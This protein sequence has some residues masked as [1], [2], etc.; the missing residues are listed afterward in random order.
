MFKY[1][2][3][4][5]YSMFLKKIGVVFLCL[6]LMS[7][8][9]VAGS[10]YNFLESIT[11]RVPSNTP[12]LGNSDAPGDNAQAVC[13]EGE[14][15]PPRCGDGICETAEAH[16]DDQSA[17]Y[18]PDDCDY[19]PEEP[20]VEEPPQDQPPATDCVDSDGQNYNLK[21]EVRV[22]GVSYIDTCYSAEKV[23]EFVCSEGEV[24]SIVDVCPEGACTEGA[25]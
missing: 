24:K 19:A 13:L 21:G 6:I 18:C 25:C 1:I 20:P 14:P 2:G 15:Q 22:N 17:V 5:L 10:L 23:E 11:G 9:A 4:I 12:N 16:T 3:V 7:S 8:F